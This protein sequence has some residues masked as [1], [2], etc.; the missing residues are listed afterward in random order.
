[1]KDDEAGT[2]ISYVPVGAHW[3]Y[4]SYL[5]KVRDLLQVV[6]LENRYPSVSEASMLQNIVFFYFN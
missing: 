6:D 5:K 1:M 4:S 3:G 2:G